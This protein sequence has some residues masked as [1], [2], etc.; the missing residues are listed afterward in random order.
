[1]FWMDIWIFLEYRGVLTCKLARVS[2]C[3]S[4]PPRRQADAGRQSRVHFFSRSG[5]SGPCRDLV[6]SS[7]LWSSRMR[8]PVISSFFSQNPKNV[9][10]ANP[11]EPL[12]RDMSPIDLTI[13]DGEEPPPKKLKTTHERALR[14]PQLQPQSARSH[15]PASQ[16]RYEPSQSPERR[17]I[18][19]EAKKRR[20]Q[21]AR[22]LIANDPSMRADDLCST[23]AEHAQGV[24][25][26]S[27]AESEGKF[28]Q[29]QELFARK[30]EQRKKGKATQDK[31]SKK[32]AELG[33][34]GEPY[35]ALELQVN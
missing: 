14:S 8:Q 17:L 6:A 22:L 16:W 28:K 12:S 34:S 13:S 9:S 29:L 1:M 23:P 7:R 3:T 32:Q 10:S 20:E 2:A 33:P 30:T 24:S 31:P 21:F 15:L 27:E 26:C 11:S 35:T 25:D 18:G 19:P 4:S 5:W